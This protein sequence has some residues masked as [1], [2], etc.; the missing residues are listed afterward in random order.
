MS[1]LVNKGTKVITQGISGKSGRFHTEQGL[2]Y[3]SQ[4]VGGVTPGKGGQEILGLPIFETVYDAKKATGCDASVIFVP[5]PL[6][7]MPFWKQRMLG[8]L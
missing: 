5:L 3:G 6:R 2:E 4:F 7:Q 1:I 8:L